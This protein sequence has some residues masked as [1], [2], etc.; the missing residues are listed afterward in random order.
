MWYY[1]E[2]NGKI[3]EQHQQKGSA[4]TAKLVGEMWKNLTNDAKEVYIERARQ[5]KLRFDRELDAEKEANGG[6]RLCTAGEMKAKIAKLQED[7]DKKS[8]QIATQPAVKTDQPEPKKQVAKKPLSNFFIY[9]K[10]RRMEL[11]EQN[12]PRFQS[13]DGMKQFMKQ[14]GSEWKAFTEE[15]KALFRHDTPLGQQIIAQSENVSANTAQRYQ[16]L[17]NRQNKTVNDD[18]NQVSEEH[19]CADQDQTLVV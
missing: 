5:D 14:L 16:Q 2:M 3:R 12:D 17:K 6:N 9:I 13:V 4:D 19:P 10:K 15:Q 11:R 8:A 7:F 18:E 1:A